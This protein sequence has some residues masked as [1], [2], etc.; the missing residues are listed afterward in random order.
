LRSIYLN[1]TWD[2]FH[3]YRIQKEQNALYGQI[4]A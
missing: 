4:A 2:H 1:K 3:E